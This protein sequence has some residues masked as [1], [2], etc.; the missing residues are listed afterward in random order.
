M[1]PLFHSLALTF[2]SIP[3]SL[4]VEQV[5][6]GEE[7]PRTVI[8]GLVKYV[9]IEEMQVNTLGQRMVLS[10]CASKPSLVHNLSASKL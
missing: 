4:Y 1:I 6:V 10:A 2:N 8:S 7:A 9:P 5:D 3:F